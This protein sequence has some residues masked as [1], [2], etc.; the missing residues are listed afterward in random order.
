MLSGIYRKLK[1]Y[2]KGTSLDQDNLIIALQLRNIFEKCIRWKVAIIDQSGKKRFSV[3]IAF[4]S[5]FTASD[6]NWETIL[7]SRADLF[8]AK[9]QVLK[10]NT[11][12][13]S[14][15]LVLTFNHNRR[16]D[17]DALSEIYKQRKFTDLTLQFGDK[18]I[19]VHRALL[20]ACSPLLNSRF[21]E[22]PE[23]SNVLDLED[24]GV[25]FEV[26]E[27]MVNFVYD[28]KVEEMEK[29]AK[30]LLAA[31]VKLGMPSLKAY[32][33]ENLYKN[34]VVENVIETLILSAR[35]SADRLK[36]ECIGFI[37]K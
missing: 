12:T 27:H 16:A 3:E 5:D 20:A 37:Q 4:N 36:K 9:H 30:P 19:K 11:L 13:L 7:V 23:N 2:P 31:A 34:L 29:Y 25:E 15:K 14:V 21:N 10:D 28:E 22:L 33:L 35:L 32:C 8:K 26:A 6:Q 24:V 18:S 17:K 1:V